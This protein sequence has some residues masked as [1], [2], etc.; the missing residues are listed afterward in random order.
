MCIYGIHV[1]FLKLLTG[2]VHMLKRI[3]GIGSVI[4][5]FVVIFF[6]GIFRPVPVQASGVFPD[7]PA[8]NLKAAGTK[9]TAVLAGGCFWGM[10]GVFERL[11]GVT[12]VVSGYSGGDKS[13]A[14]YDI[15]STGRT[16]HAESI[17][18]EFDPSKITFGTLLK[19]YFSVAHDPTQL[20]YQGPD[21]GTQYRSVIFYTNAAQEKIAREYIRIIDNA[22]VFKDP[23]VTQV[24]PFKAFYQAEAY[25]QDFMDNHPNNP[26]IVYW[27]LPKIALLKEKYPELVARP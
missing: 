21:H 1:L 4:S 12:D 25:H 8:Q 19:V 6:A 10:E 16:G 11:K 2:E 17:R 7:P 15:V 22:G 3:I 23:I 20:N 13:T 5:I 18:I 24:V 27:D 14:K 26:Y 9:E